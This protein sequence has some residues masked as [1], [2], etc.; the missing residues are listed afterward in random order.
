MATLLDREQKRL[1]KRFHTLFGK[2]G[3]SNYEKQV[4]LT[5]YGV[6]S[7]KELSAY[8][9]LE[10]CDK[11]DKI[12]NP[13]AKELDIWRKR[14]IASVGGWLRMVGTS[15]NNLLLIKAIACQATK[16]DSFNKIPLERLRNVYYTFKNKQKD[17][18]QIEVVSEEMIKRIAMLN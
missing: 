12:S 13:K 11:L 3:M 4:I 7:S 8:Q 18:E 10:I 2:Y 16:S 1:L 14:V 15:G 17:F 5:S 6:E 9:L